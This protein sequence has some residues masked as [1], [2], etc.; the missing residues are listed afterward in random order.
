MNPLGDAD[1]VD[2]LATRCDHDAAW[3]E[4]IGHRWTGRLDSARWSCA[5]AERF[6]GVVRSRDADARRHADELHQLATDLRRH[7]AW[8]RNRTEQLANL[9]RRVR[10]WFHQHTP[11]P[12]GGIAVWVQWGIHPTFPAPAHPDWEQL[13]AQ[14][15]RFG[16]AV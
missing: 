7:A 13:A 14:L 11:L 4:D 2:R 15:R 16:A 8:I 1:S 6:R 9:E 12:D 10:D 5:K 3:L